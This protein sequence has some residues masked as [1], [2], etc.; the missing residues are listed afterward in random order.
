LIWPFQ[1]RRLE[2]EGDADNA[3]KPDAPK[4]T[5]T[6]QMLQVEPAL[7]CNLA[8]TMCPWRKEAGRSGK[9]GLMAEPVWAAIRSWLSEADRIDFTGGGEPLMQPRLNRWIREAADAGC[10]TGFL[11][12][13]SLLNDAMAR[14]LVDDGLDWIGFSVDGATADVYEAI[15]P[16]AD[17]RRICASMAGMALL[18]QKRRPRMILNFVMMA[19][20]IH[21]L[22]DLVYLAADLGIDHVNF[23]Q[24]DVIR[25]V[26]EDAGGL[27]A[28]IRSK[29]VRILEKKLK[30]AC[31]LAEK[32]GLQTTAYAFTPDELP[33][34]PPDPVHALFIARDGRVS[35][36]INMAYGGP[37]RFFDKPV[38]LPRLS[39]GRLPEQDLMEIWQSEPCAAFRER[40]RLRERAYSRAL[41]NSQFEASLIKLEEAFQDARKAMP[42]AAEGCRVCHY[43]YG[44]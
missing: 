43:L 35:P 28:E 13:G 34:C 14:Q 6:W 23:K 21:Q 9:A 12:N 25:P 33:V 42:P 22:E 30:K 19:I 8:C 24:C 38:V 16:G 29:N 36:C 32:L 39:F 26:N 15:R 20:N 5:R 18:K 3:S 31:R 7:A 40:F 17:F 37:S 11:T 27:Q 4:P 41:G 10:Q 2:P 1:K 44:V